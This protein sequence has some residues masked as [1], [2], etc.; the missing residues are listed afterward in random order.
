[1]V[2]QW[3]TNEYVVEFQKA[4]GLIDIAEEV[5]ANPLHSFNVNYNDLYK[6]LN[7]TINAKEAIYQHDPQYDIKKFL[8]LVLEGQANN[9]FIQA[10]FKMQ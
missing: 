9:N 3:K 8:P 2:V 5:N 6:D 10:L 7:I 4:L 1:M